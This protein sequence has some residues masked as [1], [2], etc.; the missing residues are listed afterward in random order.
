MSTDAKSPQEATNSPAYVTKA[1]LCALT[2]LSPATIQRYKYDGR[3]PFFQPGGP[4][5]RVLFPRNAI[6]IA[7]AVRRQ[8]AGPEVPIL[9]ATNEG[10]ALR[11]RPGPPPRWRSA[12]A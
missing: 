2:G 10:V 4:G 6:E 9:N 3:I 7:M 8:E 5:A 12:G 11:K 1:E